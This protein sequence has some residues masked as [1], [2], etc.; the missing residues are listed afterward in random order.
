M[1]F[2]KKK[3]KLKKKKD[4][5]SGNLFSLFLHGLYKQGVMLLLTRGTERERERCMAW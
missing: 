3:E 2:Q 5:N 4:L 1:K